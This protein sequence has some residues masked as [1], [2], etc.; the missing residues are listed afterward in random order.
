MDNVCH[1]LVGAALA[2]TGLKRRTRLG[3]ATLMIG[4]NF[5]DVDVATIPFGRAIEMRRGWTHGVLALV[6]LP[7]VLT[8]LMLAWDRS[9]RGR[10]GD[11]GQSVVPREVLLLA[12]I[13]IL[14]HPTLDWMNSYGLRWLMPFS[15]RWFYGDALFIIDPWLLLVLGAGV[16]ASRRR[17]GKR[18]AHASRPARVAVAVAAGYVLAM[19]ALHGIARTMAERELSESDRAR[20][21]LHVMPSPADPL[22]WTLLADDG[23]RYWPGRVSL[24]APRGSRVAL[25]YAPIEKRADDPAARAASRTTTGRRFLGWARMPYYEIERRGGAARVTITDARYGASVELRVE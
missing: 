1:T 6:V 7:F 17:E 11:G 15:G 9:R 13:S 4:A 21:A 25:S 20:R 3:A 14:T 16:W 8:A 23:A 2:E 18:L 24:L 19:L 12:A 5:P 10:G 22:R